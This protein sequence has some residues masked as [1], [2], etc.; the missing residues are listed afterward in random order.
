MSN[1][2]SVLGISVDEAVAA[3]IRAIAEEKGVG[4]GE[5]GEALLKRGLETGGALKFKRR[6]REVVV[7][8]VEETVN[9]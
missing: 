1:G 3:K 8:E 6:K 4:L 2:K 7:T 5:L 9:L